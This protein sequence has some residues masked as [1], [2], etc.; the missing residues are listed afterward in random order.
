MKNIDTEK[1]KDF[2]EDIRKRKQECKQN[3]NHIGPESNLTINILDNYRRSYCQ[4]CMASYERSLTKKEVQERN[5]AYRN[6]QKPF[7]I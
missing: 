2:V 3:D 5:Q 4:H 7:N 1:I 6:M